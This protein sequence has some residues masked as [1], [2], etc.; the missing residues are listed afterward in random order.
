MSFVYFIILIGVLIFVHE[1]G[2]FIFAKLFD[3]KVLRFSIGMGP[4]LVSYTKG[5]TEYVIC[6]LPLGGYVR[7]L[8]YELGEVEEIAD[9]DRDR[10]LMMKPIWQR[11]LIA[12]A[13]PVFNLILPV[14]IYF[15]A[16]MAQGTAPPA[17]IGEVFAETP[18]AEVGLQ[19]GDKVVAIDGEEVTYWHELSETIGESYGREIDVTFIRDGERH[20]V[21]VEPE[22]KRTTDFM[23]LRE[24]TYGMLGIHLQPHG[25]T[26]GI[27]NP[28]SPAAK[29]GL[30]TF[31]KIEAVDGEHVERFDE[32]ESKVR[33]SGG[34][35]LDM[36][37]LHRVPVDPG[38]ARF[39]AQQVDEIT[40]SATKTD[41]GYELGL[42][43][44]EMFVAKVEEDSPA[45]KAGLQTGDKLVAL[46][47]RE[48][49]N[50]SLLNRKITNDVNEKIVELQEEGVEDIEV[51][52]EYELSYERDGE[53]V[54]TTLAPEVTKFKGQG[55]QERYRVY[56][57]WGHISERVA[58]PEVAFPFFPRMAY[59]AE[60]SVEQTWEFCEMIVMGFVR[61]A[62]GRVSLDN[63]GGPIMIGE[64]AAEAGKAGWQPFLQM[65]ALISINL[66]IINLLPIPVL[67][68]GHLLL[69]ALEAVKRGPL[70]YRT[71]QIAAYIGIAMIVFLMVLAFKNDIE[72]NWEDIAEWINQE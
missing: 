15:V 22:T 57:G 66:G 55:N 44:A 11:S 48:H 23:G 40:A 64:L 33:Q 51:E 65:M 52:P 24:Q 42:E 39:Y 63:L 38:Y 41:D 53:T 45:A 61:M 62:Q 71:R 69:Y 20:E 7:M 37:V 28:D 14:V 50:W 67:D 34:E 4:T 3:V 25:T 8:G 27:S 68:G 13:G 70:S 59:A 18:A 1:L 16:T 29:A 12:L 17:V 26:V 72:R 35:P 5:E 36:V 10:A 54:T 2:H 49:S 30:K 60:V 21:R 47:G 31:D 58:A 43:P 32:V 46:D 56:I 9:E 6:A 19:P